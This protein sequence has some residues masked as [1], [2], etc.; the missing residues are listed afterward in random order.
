MT[1]QKPLTFVAFAEDTAAPNHCLCYAST[2][3]QSV[4]GQVLQLRVSGQSMTT[5]GTLTASL[6]EPDGQQCQSTATD[7]ASEA[8][9]LHEH[10]AAQLPPDLPP[11]L[12]QDLAKHHHPLMFVISQGP[13]DDEDE[14]V[15]DACADLLQ[16]NYPVLVLPLATPTDHMPRRILIAADREPFRLADNSLPLRELLALPRTKY[17]VVHVAGALEDGLGYGLAEKAVLGSRLFE[18]LPAP[19]LLSYEY[20]NYARGLLAAVQDTRADLIVV[21]ARQRSYFSELFHRSVTA[22]L[23]QTCPVPV[24]VLPT[25]HAHLYNSF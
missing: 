20:G 11:A 2:L 7:Q 21:L 22:R 16:T 3:A 12:V 5:P 1:P 4:N 25:D 13:P 23:L 19:E 15:V 24:L 9:K 8:Y 14:E 18:G 6:F 17:H 10:P